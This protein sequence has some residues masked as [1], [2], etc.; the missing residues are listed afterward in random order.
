[1]GVAPPP[2]ERPLPAGALC[3]SRSSRARSSALAC[4]RTRASCAGMRRAAPGSG[5][6]APGS[7]RAARTPAS[8]P[9]AGRALA[10]PVGP[11]RRGWPSTRA[12]RCGGATGRARS[13]AGVWCGGPAWPRKS[14]SRSTGHCRRPSRP[15]RAC[16]SVCQGAGRGR[17]G[18]A[19]SRV[20]GPL[21]ASRRRRRTRAWQPVGL[22]LTPRQRLEAEWRARWRR[23]EDPAGKPV[24]HRFTR[25]GSGGQSVWR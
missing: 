15:A 14:A 5:S 7:R 18:R 23:R 6:T 9:P 11:K 8:P 4:L 21:R 16:A 13:R 17:A 3:S 24:C 2:R 12:G 19:P 22:L 20:L 1:M 10:A 25:R